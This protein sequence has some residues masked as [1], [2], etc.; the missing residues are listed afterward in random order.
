RARERR[1]GGE[2]G[3][4][5]AASLHPSG[6]ARKW[7]RGRALSPRSGY[8]ESAGVGTTQQGS[9]C[10]RIAAQPA[11]QLDEHLSLRG[12]GVRIARRERQRLIELA[13]GARD[14]PEQGEPARRLATQPCE[15]PEIAEHGEMRGG[16]LRIGP[17]G[18]LRAAQTTRQ[19]ACAVPK[20]RG[21]GGGA[22]A[23]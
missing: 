9:P 5:H 15:L 20:R 21:V 11:R 19:D 6:A 17:L 3:G 22:P 2:V 16:I 14:V 7:L 12:H 23:K 10:L 4:I 8:V 1:E 13:S 18:F